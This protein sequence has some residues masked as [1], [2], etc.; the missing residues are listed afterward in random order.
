MFGL[1]P[2]FKKGVAL[3]MTPNEARIEAIGKAL[4]LVGATMG[5]IG[6]VIAL[7]AN[8]AVKQ[9][10]D[11]VYTQLPKE[12]QDNKIIVIMGVS[13]LAAIILARRIKIMSQKTAKERYK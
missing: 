4:G 2:D 8:P 13:A 11:G 6:T 5:T 12:V 10:A 3:R 1:I 9:T 7:T